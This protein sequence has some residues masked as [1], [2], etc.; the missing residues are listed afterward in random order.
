MENDK[1]KY[2]TICYPHLRTGI[3]KSSIIA[4]SD[5]LS[6]AKSDLKGS[7]KRAIGNALSNIKKAIHSRIDEIIGLTH[8]AYA[9]DWKCFISTE[10]KLAILKTIGIGYRSIV[11]I[12]TNIRNDYEHKYILPNIDTARAYCETAE[13]WMGNSIKEH[14]IGRLGICNLPVSSVVAD[15]DRN[16]LKLTI[17]DYD[18]VDI[19]YFWDTERI[20]IGT[21]LDR[22]NDT[23]P[24][25]QLAY[26]EI[27][28][29]EGKY[30]K[31]VK[32]SGNFYFLSQKNITKLFNYYD[33]KL[34]RKRGFFSIGSCLTFD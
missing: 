15:E 12:I 11:S 19:Y 29:R 23:K 13:L 5:F 9:K 17:A 28:A 34:N 3:N 8:V 4:P 14:S 27:L 30:I 33:K 22:R 24:L 6:W 1:V 7:D 26:K 32:K 2:I 21:T 16:I 31:E 10:D 18:Y 25:N 20:L